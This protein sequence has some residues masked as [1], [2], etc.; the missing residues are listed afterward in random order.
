MD[1]QLAILPLIGNVNMTVLD[2]ELAPDS[3]PV[4]LAAPPI[5]LENSVFPMPALPRDTEGWCGCAE[6]PAS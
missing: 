3:T 4:L 2:M 6:R 5:A 1:R